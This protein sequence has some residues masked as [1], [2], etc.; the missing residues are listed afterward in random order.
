MTR[1][2]FVAGRVYLNEVELKDD[3]IL[4]IE[5]E[6]FKVDYLEYPV[7]MLLTKAGGMSV[8]VTDSLTWRMNKM[9]FLLDD[10]VEKLS[11]VYVMVSD[12]SADPKPSAP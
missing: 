12:G 5:G 3:A 11:D 4:G 2:T 10:P 1:V 9:G 8:L 7:V 6:P